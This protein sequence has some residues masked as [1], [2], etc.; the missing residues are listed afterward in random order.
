MTQTNSWLAVR[1]ESYDEYSVY[2]LGNLIIAT[3]Q[4]AANEDYWEIVIIN[5]KDEQEVRWL[6][7]PERPSVNDI[8]VFHNTHF[9]K[10]EVRTHG[11]DED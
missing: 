10:K 8:T 6:C 3:A 1:Q 7:T 11:E 4:Y 2:F 5:E 9:N